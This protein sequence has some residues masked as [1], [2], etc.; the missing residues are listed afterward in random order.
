MKAFIR[1]LLSGK[2]QPSEYA[3]MAKVYLELI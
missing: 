3:H 2:I 1:W